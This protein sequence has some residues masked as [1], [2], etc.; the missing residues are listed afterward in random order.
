MHNQNAV[1]ILS[2]MR[3][4]EFIVGAGLA[5]VLMALAFMASLFFGG[6]YRSETFMT[7]IA[8]IALVLGSILFATR[9]QK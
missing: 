7:S 1:T 3:I 9:R 4:T 2:P 6:Q 5:A 8:M